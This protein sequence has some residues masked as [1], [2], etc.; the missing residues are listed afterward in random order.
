MG[1]PAGGER[2]RDGVGVATRAPRAYGQY[3][4]LSRALERVGER[5]ALLIVRDLLAGARRYGDLKSGLPRIPTNILSDRLRELQ[6]AGI[7]RRVPMV[8]GGYELTELGRAL[9]PAVLALERWGWSAL[10]EPGEGESI[11]HDAIA[12][13]LRAAFRAPEA[14]AAPPTRFVVRIGEVE[15][16]ATVTGGDLILR[17][18][19]PGAVPAPREERPAAMAEESVSVSCD[20]A[21]LRDLIAGT[22][23]PAE[24][25]RTGDATILAGDGGVFDRFAR[26][27]RIEP[28]G[29]AAP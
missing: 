22:R 12:A 3:S 7:V 20:A 17:A 18:V 13:T 5:W 4:G 29:P 10:G 23:T 2:R 19:G 14:R 27:F 9:E 11:S 6:E 26:V 25:L 15:I 24:V 28:I 1:G 16:A 21:V 8:R